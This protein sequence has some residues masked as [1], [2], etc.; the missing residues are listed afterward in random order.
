MSDRYIIV[1]DY[2]EGANIE[3]HAE[4][5]KKW[6]EASEMPPFPSVVVYRPFGVGA[7][8]VLTFYKCGTT[9]S[10]ELLDQLDREVPGFRWNV[11]LVG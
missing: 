8:V 3:R 4:A 1:S 7:A 5:L 9:D 10:F 6:N 2:I 11:V